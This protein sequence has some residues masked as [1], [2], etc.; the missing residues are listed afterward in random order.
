MANKKVT[1]K[2]IAEMANVSPSAVSFVL[3]GRDGVSEA[4]KKKILAAIKETDYHPSAASQR[5]VLQKS[6]NI[7]FVYPPDVSPF[8]DL[9]YYEVANGLVD[10]LTAK[11]YNMVFTP[12]IS[13]DGN[14]T[15][16]NIIKRRDADG[17]V[18]LHHIP[19]TLLDKLDEM[20]LPYVLVDWQSNDTKR[21]N[22]SLDCEQSIFNAVMYLINKGHS[23]I[24]F[25]GS[26]QLPFYYL[27]CFTGYQNALSEAQLP[28]YPGWLHNSIH[29]TENALVVLEKL[30]A[31]PVPPTAICFMNDMSAIYALQ[32]AMQLGIQVPEELSFISIDDILLSRYT[33]PQLT[34][35][36]YKKNEIG[37]TAAQ[38]LL[39]LIEGQ[40][41]ES[42]VIRSD[43]ILERQSVADI[44]IK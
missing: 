17:V 3:N 13:E 15:I 7:A 44:A 10:A 23:K 6:F 30:K 33:H 14:I 35:I 21:T 36:S 8:T 24:A 2:E 39:Q 19:A 22:V 27:R 12:L 9:F 11:Q 29:S 41:A 34:T 1:I 31:L 26:D 37:K 40:A 42:V 4:T 16:P 43:V 38:L 32:A 28:I 20:E 25:L 5:L 18:F